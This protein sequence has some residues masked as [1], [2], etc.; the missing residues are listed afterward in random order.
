MVQIYIIFLM[1]FKSRKKW[2]LYIYVYRRIHHTYA[3]LLWVPSI[4]LQLPPWF[5]EEP[6]LL[7]FFHATNSMPQ[8][9][10][11]MVPRC[12]HI[13]MTYQLFQ[14]GRVRLV[15]LVSIFSPTHLVS[16]NSEPFGYNTNIYFC[17]LFRFLFGLHRA[18]WF[19]V[20][21]AFE[22]VSAR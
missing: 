3:L 16:V 13:R 8:F 14:I 18:M 1:I 9:A 6:E 7:H 11:T 17:G 15:S 2:K 5:S 12:T 21:L 10:A 22:W 19:Y 20:N 4:V